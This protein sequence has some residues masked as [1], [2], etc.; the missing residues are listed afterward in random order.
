MRLD[1][2]Y[3]FTQNTPDLRFAVLVSGSLIHDQL[4]DHQHH[5][6]THDLQGTGACAVDL[7]LSGKTAQHTQLGTDHAIIWDSAV[8]IDQ[9]RFDHIDVTACFC[10]G[11]RCYQ[12]DNNGHTNWILDEFYAYM[13]HNGVVTLH[14][15][16]PIWQ[17][18]LE[19]CQ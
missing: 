13:G 9:I 4:S 2:C 17:W 7:M 8:I 15:S 16:L 11:Q 3:H 19:Q 12:H 1:L 18:F 6:I 10:Q 14:F 5:T